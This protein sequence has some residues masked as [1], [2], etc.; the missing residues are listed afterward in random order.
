M[1]DTQIGFCPIAKR[2]CYQG[3]CVET[4]PSGKWGYINRRGIMTDQPTEPQCVFWKKGK[5]KFE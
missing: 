2:M 4:A 1:I 5:C 3:Y